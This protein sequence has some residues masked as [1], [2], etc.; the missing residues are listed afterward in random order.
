MPC[1]FLL[2]LTKASHIVTSI[3]IHP[4]HC[5]TQALDVEMRTCIMNQRTRLDLQQFST[6]AEA[7]TSYS[8]S[9]F[10][11]WVYQIKYSSARASA[12]DTMYSYSWSC[13]PAAR[14]TGKW[15]S[16][17]AWPPRWLKGRRAYNQ[18]GRSEIPLPR[19]RLVM[20][21][22]ATYAWELYR[23]LRL[24]RVVLS[25]LTSSDHLRAPVRLLARQPDFIARVGSTVWWSYSPP[26]WLSANVLY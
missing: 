24:L 20:W 18:M 11:V 2:I 4:S 6:H 25:A 10:C 19:K 15:K 8:K 17:H 13:E 26:C 3:G 12:D 1:S 5:P 16:A 9:T 22:W 23:S 21:A 14:A 7:G